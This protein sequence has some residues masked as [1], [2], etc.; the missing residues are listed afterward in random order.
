MDELDG[1]KQWKCPKR[2]HPGG[3]GASEFYNTGRPLWHVSRLM[4]YRQA[5][6][7]DLGVEVDV[8]AAVEGTALTCRCSI[9]GEVRPWIIGEDAVQRLLE[10]M[11]GGSHANQGGEW[12]DIFLERC[13][14][15]HQGQPGVR[16]IAGRWPWRSGLQGMNKPG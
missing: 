1:L 7:V 8:I 12:W 4:L 3:G 11:N 15:L 16:Q 6:S 2:S 13:T 14:R 5:I 10:K 9:C